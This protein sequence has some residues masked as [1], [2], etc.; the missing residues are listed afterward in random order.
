M[1]PEETEREEE[2]RRRGEDQTKREEGGGKER[3]AHSRGPGRTLRRP[4]VCQVRIG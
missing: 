2:T 1:I 4:A 3:E